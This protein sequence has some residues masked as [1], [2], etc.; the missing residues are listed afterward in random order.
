MDDTVSQKS[1]ASISSLHGILDLCLG[2]S[3]CTSQG[4]SSTC[5]GVCDSQMVYEH[6][7]SGSS[8]D[9]LICSHKMKSC[10]D[11]CKIELDLYLSDTFL[12]F[13]G[14]YQCSN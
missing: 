7:H 9:L 14:K 4:C 11:I 6:K 8:H 3:F 12:I 1:Y 2:Y 13:F 5:Q 10:I